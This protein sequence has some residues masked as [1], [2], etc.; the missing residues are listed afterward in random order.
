MIDREAK[1]KRIQELGGEVERRLAAGTVT[2]AFMDD[3]ELET[4]QIEAELKGHK[5]A[6]E[7]RAG[8]EIGEP[9]P[10]AEG[11]VAPASVVNP[12]RFDMESLKSMHQA[13]KQRQNYQISA[14]AGGGFADDISLKTP[15][16]FSSPVSSLPPQL[17]P[18]VLPPI[19][20]SRIMDRLPAMQITAPVL[21]YIQHV[22]SSGTPGIVAEGASKPEVTFNINK[23][24]VTALKLACHIAV[25]WES[26][27]DSGG[28]GGLQDWVGYVTAEIFREVQDRENF[29]LLS[30]TGGPSNIQGFFSTPGILTHD[31]SADTGTGVTSLDSVEESIARMRTG[32]A[33]AEPNLFITHPVT[34][35][36][37]RRTKDG[38][39]RFLIAPD[40]TQDEAKML[41]GIPVLTTIACQLGQGLLIDT[42]K[43]GKVV[44]REALSMRTGYDAGDAI[45]NLV[46]LIVEERF[47]L[48]VER[49]TAI[50]AI[51]NLPYSGGS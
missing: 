43:F 23:I 8:S 44:V 26:I 47:N 46:R 14:K 41:W 13:I 22:S 32:T 27:Q 31:A 49:P 28:D 24:L 38:F 18:Y 9:I 25:S 12:L 3:I 1:R 51:S 11:Q 7:F 50:L 20:E 21:E 40:P 30:G 33:L 16:V 19:H 5:R 4:K 37:M 29:L 45:A 15:G 2:K 35:S 34:W 6:L 42:T 48:A 10:V 39:Q 36:A 17:Y